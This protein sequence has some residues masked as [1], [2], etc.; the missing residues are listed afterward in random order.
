MNLP[1]IFPATVAL[2]FWVALWH[3]VSFLPLLTSFPPALFVA[4]L[5]WLFTGWVWPLD[6]REAS[7]PTPDG[8]PICRI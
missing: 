6:A 3:V 1:P 7:P 2:I 4:A 5:T 8:V